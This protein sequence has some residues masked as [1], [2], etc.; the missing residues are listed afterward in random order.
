MSGYGVAEPTNFTDIPVID[1]AGMSDPGRRAALAA[2]LVETAQTVGFFYISGHGVPAD[3]RAE[4]FAASAQ[5]FALPEATKAQVRVD[6][7]QRGWMAQG[8]STLE[9]SKT[10][11]AKEVFF[12]GWDVAPD[13]PDL[14]LPLVALN[15]WPTAVPL[16]DRLLPYYRAVVALGRQVLALLAEGLDADSQVLQ[17]AY[18]KPLARGQLVYY[19][20]VD[21]QDTSV[22]RYSAAPHT[23]FGVLTLLAQDDRGGLQVRNAAGDWIEAPPVPDT[24][25]CNIGDLLQHWSGGRLRSTAHRVINRSG[26]PRFSIPVFCDPASATRIDPSELIPGTPQGEVMTAGAYIAGKNRRNFAHY[27]R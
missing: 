5:F 14:G 8:L 9:G 6:Q 22:E 2:Q 7:N 1:L 12:W 11:D 23:D 13:D 16:R 18:E 15:Q 3:L 24:Y 17:R 20:P 21:E 27:N 4:A 10:H 25:V 19:P 26:Q